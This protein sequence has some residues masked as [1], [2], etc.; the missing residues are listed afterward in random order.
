MELYK[1]LSKYQCK[2]YAEV[3]NRGLNEMRL[4]KDKLNR[5]NDTPESESNHSERKKGRKK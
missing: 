4:G 2:T 1:E 3:M 5:D